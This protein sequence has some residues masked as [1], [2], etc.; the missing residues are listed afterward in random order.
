MAYIYEIVNDVNQKRYIGKTEFDINKRFKEHCRDAFRE[1]N[2]KRPLYRAMRKYGIEHFSVRLIEKTDVPEEREA[3]WIEQ[4]DTYHNGYN[5]TRGGDGKKYLDYDLIISTYKET[6]NIK[7]VAEKL[8]CDEHTVGQIL[9]NNNI[10]IKSQKEINLE[11]YGKKIG[12]FSLDDK[13]LNIFSSV[14][15]ASRS[16]GKPHNH[17]SQCIN[18]K[19]KTAYGY[20]WQYL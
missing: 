7:K 14:N 6:Q 1:R 17:I 9:K 13:L 19:R 11:K 10:S 15:E 3:Y 2:E 12:Q 5:A 4:K 8:N 20:I 18:G 16:I